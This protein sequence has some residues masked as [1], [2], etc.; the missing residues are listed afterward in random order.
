M[1]PIGT[2]VTGLADFPY[3][4]AGFHRGRYHPL[5]VGQYRAL[6]VVEADVITIER[7]HVGNAALAEALNCSL[8][9]AD[10]R[11]SRAAGARCPITVVPR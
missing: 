5:R 1:R 7:A 11:L 4:A 3:P 8:I 10:A 2:A 9:T 6:Y